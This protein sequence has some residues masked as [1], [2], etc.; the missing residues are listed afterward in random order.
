[1]A[2]TLKMDA[3]RLSKLE[4][5]HKYGY[6]K[7]MYTSDLEIYMGQKWETI[8]KNFGHR[9]DFPMRQFGTVW[10]VPLDDWKGFLSACYTGQIYKGLKSAEFE[11]EE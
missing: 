2:S 3:E 7:I 4:Q 11:Q 8:K 6:P 9:P 1:M 5:Y 10:S